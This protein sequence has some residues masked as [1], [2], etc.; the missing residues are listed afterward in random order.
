ME[1]GRYKREDAIIREN[2]GKGQ[3][4]EL[5][6]NERIKKQKKFKRE[7]NWIGVIKRRV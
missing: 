4:I 7:R 1:E 2:K 5:R 6:S 3:D